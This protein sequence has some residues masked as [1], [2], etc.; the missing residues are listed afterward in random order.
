MSFKW[1]MIDTETTGIYPPVYVIEI[2][3]QKM[4]GFK[5]KGKPFHA[6]LN[7]SVRIPLEAT[8]VHGITQSFI[9]RK[10]LDPRKVHNDFDEYVGKRP[11]AAHNLNFD[12]NCLND[13]RRR[14]GISKD[15]NAQL[16]TVLLSRRIL[17]ELNSVKLDHLKDYFGIEAKSHRA[18]SDVK[19]VV[20]LFKKIFRKRLK[21]LGINS[22]PKLK[23]LSVTTPVARYHPLIQKKVR[24]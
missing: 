4:R 18:N 3:A 20:K 15:I 14:L 10:G 1:V 24:D 19:I 16:C 9:R 23:Q 11:I 17:P 2:A 6:F 5:A 12:R 8:A 13:E 22:W 21:L 7:H